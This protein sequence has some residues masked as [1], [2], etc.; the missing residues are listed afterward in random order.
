MI[1]GKSKSLVIVIV[2]GILMSFALNV[3]YFKD[4]FIRVSDYLVISM[5][6]LNLLISTLNFNIKNSFFKIFLF[7]SVFYF[8][9]ATSNSDEL[10][11]SNGGIRMLKIIGL[12]NISEN[13]LSV[14]LYLHLSVLVLLSIIEIIIIF[15]FIKEKI[16]KQIGKVPN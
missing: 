5:L 11:F 14:F 12:K 16:S 2:F 6:V 9:I 10:E 7:L 15:D 8:F 4:D 13:I 1:R 3:F